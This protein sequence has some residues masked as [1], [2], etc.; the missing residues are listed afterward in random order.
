MDQ[1]GVKIE[2][3][4]PGDG[5]EIRDGQIAVVH[6]RGRLTNGQEFDSSYSRGKPF[7]FR[8]GTGQVIKGWDI[9]VSGMKVGGK[10]TLTIPSDLGYGSRG[11]GGVI[12]PGATLIFDVELVDIGND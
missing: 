9:G 12:P 7:Q 4:N 5:S 6:Y 11:A 3:T 2:I 10:R 1:Q 8:L